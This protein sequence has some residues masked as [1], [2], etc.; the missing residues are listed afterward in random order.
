MI[1]GWVDSWAGLGTREFLSAHSGQGYPAADP[2]FIVGIQR[3]GS[4]LVEQMLASHPQVE[5]TAELSDLGNVVRQL[6]TA[7]E[8]QNL[9]L[10]EHLQ[11]VGPD[12]LHAAGEAY[13]ESTRVHRRQGRPFFTDKMPNNWMYVGLIRLILPN[14]KIIDVRRNPLDCCFSNWKQYYAKGNEQTYSME[15][16]A[17]YYADYVRHMRHF[18]S[19][20]PEGVHRVIYEELVD[21]PEGQL[22]FMLDYLQLPFDEACLSFYSNDRS[23]RTISAEQVRRPINREGVDQWKAFDQWLGPLKEALGSTMTDWQR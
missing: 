7:A 3:S 11:Q 23:V 22:R 10:F 20:D 8:G 6:G 13:I 16:M 19:V 21:D 18:E 17:R 1:S 14:A 15:T 2:I 12:E 9:T 5:G 4:T